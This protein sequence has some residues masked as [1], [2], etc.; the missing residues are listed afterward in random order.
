MSQERQLNILG[1]PLIPCSMDPLTGY[2]R[3]GCCQTDASDRGSHVVCVVMT[4]DFLDFSLRHG[5]DLITPRPEFQSPGLKPG[6][7]WCLCGLRWVEAIR[8]GIVAPIIL[9]ATHEKI[10]EHVSLE[11]L[12]HNAYRKIH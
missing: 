6:D 8:Q 11:T 10:L 9:E 7:F 4:A 2:F 3:D 1:E 12:V 5:N